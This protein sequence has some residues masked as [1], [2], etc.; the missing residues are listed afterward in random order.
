MS[1]D[2]CPSFAKGRQRL[3][4]ML[5]SGA[6]CNGSSLLQRRGGADHLILHA[7][8]GQ[9]WERRPFCGLDY[10]DDAFGATLRVAMEEHGYTSEI[11]DMKYLHSIPWNGL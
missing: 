3:L 2:E 11:P 9:R 10:E 7:R 8:T 4:A 5:T 6:Q 1:E